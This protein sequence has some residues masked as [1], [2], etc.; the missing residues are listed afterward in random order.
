MLQQSSPD[1][2][3][4]RLDVGLGRDLAVA[5]LQ[6][7]AGDERVVAS[8]QYLVEEVVRL[9]LGA[10]QR[11]RERVRQGGERRRDRLGGGVGDGPREGPQDAVRMIGREG[12][13]AV[14]CPDAATGRLRLLF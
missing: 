10:L 11:K 8:A 1:L 12:A 2:L 3:D 6:V 14:A 9:A 5:Q 7:D 4:E 13:E